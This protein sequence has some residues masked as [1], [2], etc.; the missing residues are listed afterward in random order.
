MAAKSGLGRIFAGPSFHFIFIIIFFLASS[1]SLL[2]QPGQTSSNFF[3]YLFNLSKG[4]QLR[5]SFTY[6]PASPAAGQPVQF[7]DS[8]TGDPSSWL[9]SF[10]DGTTSPAQ[11]PNHVFAATGFHR[12][13]LSVHSGKSTNTATRIVLVLAASTLRSSFTFSPASPLAGQAI[14][15][16]DS[17]TGGPTSWAWNFGDGAT[18]T[19]QNPSHAFA[20]AGTYTVALTAGTSSASN[21]TTR[22]VTVA[23]TLAASFTFSPASPIVNQAV[24]FTDKS[25]GGPTSWSWNFGDGA[26]S[27]AQNPSHVFAAA[28][29]YTVALTAGTSSASNRTTR[30]VT[31][32]STLAASFTFSPASPIAGQVG[33]VYRQVRRWSDIM[34]LELR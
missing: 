25:S 13:S 7:T 32:A 1:I 10:G 23:S 16:N 22:S 27:A 21:R 29:T 31:V 15:F 9:W 33:P 24:Q 14:Q 19:V 20:A 6:S 12:V 28:G 26:T 34:G 2:S 4:R 8:S 30:S 3:A 17:S 5:A 11:N 18:S